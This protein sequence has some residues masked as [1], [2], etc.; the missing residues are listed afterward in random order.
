[1]PRIS[2]LIAGSTLA[3]AVSAIALIT[4][5]A[6]AAPPAEPDRPGRYIMQPVDGGVLRMDTESGAMSLCVKRGTAL[7]CDPV[8]DDRAGQKEAERLA[9][10]NRE[11]K[12]DIK[13]LE[14]HMGLGDKPQARAPVDG[15]PADGGPSNSGRPDAGRP[16]EGRPVS[17]GNKFEL[18]S[19]EDVDKALT[20]VERMLKKFRDKWKDIEGHNGQKGTPL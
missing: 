19:E 20:Y 1:M 7:T 9:L 2:A 8:Q 17:R 16:D 3:L 14:E 13:R 11:L 5:P 18:P 4:L 15:S 10:E 12:A 6:K